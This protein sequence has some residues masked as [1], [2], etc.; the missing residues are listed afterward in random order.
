VDDT[1]QAFIQPDEGERLQEQA[2]K[3]LWYVT[4]EYSTDPPRAVL[5]KEKTMN[6]QWIFEPVSGQPRE[7]RHYI[8]NANQGKPAWL[9]ISAK[10]PRGRFMFGGKGAVELRKPLLTFDASEKQAF[11]VRHYKGPDGR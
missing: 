3:H 8:R 5:T 2:A 1:L 7:N 9:V 11:E 4:A 10:G 6:S